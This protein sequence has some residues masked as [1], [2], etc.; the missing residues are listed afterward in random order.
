MS[1]FDWV[2]FYVDVFC[3]KKSHHATYSGTDGL[4]TGTYL[5]SIYLPTSTVVHT[6]STIVQ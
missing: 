6:S 5:Y 2:E 3:E 1:D 4:L